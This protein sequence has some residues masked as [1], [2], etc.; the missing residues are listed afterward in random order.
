[1]NTTL[2]AG[3]PN[4]G[5]RLDPQRHWLV[6][7]FDP[8]VRLR[9]WW[10]VFNTPGF[11]HSALMCHLEMPDQWVHLD[12][13]ANGTTLCLLDQASGFRLLERV[14]KNGGTV[15]EW[16]VPEKR[17]V[18]PLI[19][20]PNCVSY[21]QQF[22]GLSEFRWTPY[23]L[24]LC[25]AAKGARAMFGSRLPERQSYVVRRLRAA[26]GRP[27]TLAATGHTR[28]QAGDRS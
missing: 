23:G 5:F 10:D 22:L 12:Y 26:T 27:A 15:L 20:P 18:Q 24:A 1:M 25:L 4:Q 3:N 9:W 8:I 2:L 6:L 14:V 28:H 7:F 13:G 11:R 21:C 19:Y 17:P 16:D